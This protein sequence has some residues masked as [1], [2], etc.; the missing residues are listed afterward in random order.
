M[1]I[2]ILIQS[3]ILKNHLENNDILNEDE[4]KKELSLYDKN[5][6]KNK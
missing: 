6:L 2:L 1:I 3:L 5:L 4:L